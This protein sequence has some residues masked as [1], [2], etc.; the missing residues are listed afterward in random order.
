MT[1]DRGGVNR[2][3]LTQ[4]QEPLS[5]LAGH[6]DGATFDKLKMVGNAPD[7]AV[8]RS[9]AGKQVTK[10][11]DEPEFLVSREPADEGVGVG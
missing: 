7:E 8:E 4:C 5:H 2:Y 3:F 1:S 10:A 11:A 9:A 6:L